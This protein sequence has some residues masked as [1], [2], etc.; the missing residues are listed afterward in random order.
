MIVIFSAVILEAQPMAQALGLVRQ[1]AACWADD[2]IHLHAVGIRAANLAP[3][4]LPP[5][6]RGLILAGL[7]GA[8]DPSLTIGD[9]LLDASSTALPAKP[10]CRIA[11][12]HCSA[13]IVATPYAKARLRQET[14]AMAT[15]MESA[16]VR[17]FAAANHLPFLHVRAISDTAAETLDPA[18][19]NLV[20]AL[21][22]PKPVTIA[23]TLLRKPCIIPQL[24][25]LQRNSTLATANLATAVRTI[26]AT[27]WPHT[28]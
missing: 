11:P 14:G 9:V 19:I 24:K 6:T 18:V 28:V 7:A 1:A 17:V 8:L 27:G 16:I 3:D 10:P 2:R 21:G 20:D 12:I 25:R 15:E 5:A 23:I 13:Q 22:R 26:L 4:L